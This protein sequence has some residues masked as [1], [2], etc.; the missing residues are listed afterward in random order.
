MNSAYISK[1]MELAESD[2]RV[3]HMLADSGTGYDELF[4]RNFP[5][6]IFNFG[7]GEENMVAAAAG[8]ASCGKIPFVFTAGAFL[9]YRSME[10]I[11]DDVCFQN[12]NVKVV[13]MG[14]GLSWSSLGP[15]HHTTED[16]AVLRS[17]P[18]LM[19]LSPATPIQVRDCVERAYR[20]EGPVY[21]RIGMNREKEYFEETYSNPAGNNDILTN[22]DDIS[23]FT[24]GS[25][26][27]EACK[28]VEI[29]AGEG[30]S[31]EVINVSSIKP[32]ND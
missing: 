16:I 21:I 15:T 32:F 31:V 26:L 30:I 24:T 18:N 4:R 23:L 7:I 11:R 2:Q 1:L 9:A 28:A 5:D 17:I 27:E 22:G 14:S 19:I 6:R 10:F 25:I 13:G 3:I 12:L 20:H 8:M 29:L